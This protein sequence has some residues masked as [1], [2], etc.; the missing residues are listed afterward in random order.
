MKGLRLN[1]GFDLKVLCRKNIG[2]EANDGFDFTIEQ[3]ELLKRKI[4]SRP[5]G[6][7]KFTKE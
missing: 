5:N 2:F 7:F 3:R 6:G 4:E 1:S